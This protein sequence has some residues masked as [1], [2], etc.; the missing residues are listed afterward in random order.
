[1]LVKEHIIAYLL[2]KSQPLQLE[3]KPT[4]WLH[5]HLA[6][7]GTEWLGE[8]L[9]T[10]NYLEHANRGYFL[11]YQIDGYFGTEKG[12]DYLNDIIARITITLSDCKPERLLYK[13]NMSAE[14]AHYYAKIYKLNRFSK[15]TESLRKKTQ[16]PQRA[17]AMGGKDYTFWAIKLFCEDLI[18]QFGI[19]CPVPYH[20][21][22]DWACNQ[23]EQHR[24]G[25]STVRIKC[26]SIWNY[27]DKKNWE[28]PKAY[29]KKNQKDVLMTRQEI[30]L[31]NS[32]AR[33]E[34][35][36]RKIINITSSLLSDD[37]K[38][39]TGSWHVGK[40]AED[41]NLSRKTVAKYLKELEK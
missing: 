30:A 17:D 1:M 6:G 28:L 16:A 34:K 9:P 31:K 40:I 32:Q 14:L 18:R 11:A 35:A 37:Y 22:E 10:P 2:D 20:M 12:I 8:K 25:L 41:T 38:K 15:S 4:F 19:G 33:A 39:K 3:Y 24:K 13:P 5:F 27:Y 29:I 23:F 26:R 36:R 7:D 21:V